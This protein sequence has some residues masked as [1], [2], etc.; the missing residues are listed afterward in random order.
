MIQISLVIFRELLEIL[1][2]IGVIAAASSN[3][4]KNFRLYITIGSFIGILGAILL[5]FLTPHIT[6]MFGGLGQEITNTCIIFITAG[7]LG[8]TVIWMQNYS[9]KVKSEINHIGQS[10]DQH[11]RQRILFIL[12]VAMNIFKEGAEIVLFIYSKS[13]ATNAPISTYLFSILIGGFSA[14]ICA[15]LFYRGLLKVAKIFKITSFI[16]I[17]V[18]SGLIS[19]AF[20]ILSKSGMISI[21][22]QD[23]W[24]ISWL[25]PNEGILGQFLK[26]LISYDAKP[27]ILEV[28][29]FIT[30]FTIIYISSKIA[31][32]A[33]NNS[34]KNT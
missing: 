17:I 25:I 4:I 16:F 22:S 15:F 9:T 30:T 24:D 31:K 23:A 20:G 10:S 18:A 5:A 29:A 6:D 1:L 13:L 21:F 27:S 34:Q 32:Q 2:L 33:G 3:K 26:I 28:I 12:L 11:F 8:T 7:L 19:E 14:A